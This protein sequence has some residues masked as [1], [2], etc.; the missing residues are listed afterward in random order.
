MKVCIAGCFVA[1]GYLLAEGDRPVVATRFHDLVRPSRTRPVNQST[2]ET[3]YGFCD[4]GSEYLVR[5]PLPNESILE[6]IPLEGL[7]GHPV[8]G[9]LTDD[10]EISCSGENLIL[11]PEGTLQVHLGYK[12]SGEKRTRTLSKSGK[13]IVYRWRGGHFWF[14]RDD[15]EDLRLEL[16]NHFRAQR[17]MPSLGE[18]E[19]RK[20]Y[21]LFGHLRYNFDKFEPY[22]HQFTEKMISLGVP[23][24]ELLHMWDTSETVKY[25]MFQCRNRVEAMQN[26]S[27]QEVPQKQASPAKS[28]PVRHS[29]VEIPISH[30]FR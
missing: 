20:S 9:S 5:G 14:T 16:A 2:N 27:R 24:S 15:T 12:L 10:F 8:M 13:E 6:Q 18:K 4:N 23:A 29:P 1:S 22:I 25:Y 19:Q 26:A 7:D 17:G 30:Y 3:F 11:V 28:R 21:K